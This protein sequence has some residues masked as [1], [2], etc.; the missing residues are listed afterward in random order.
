MAMDFWE[1]QR[2]A[3]KRTAWC[4]FI[5]ILMTVAVAIVSESAMR[6]FAQENYDPPLPYLAFTF[7]GLTFFVALFQ[8]GQFKAFGGAYVAESLGGLRIDPQRAT[9]QQ[10]Q[11][12]NI[13]EEIAVASSLPVPPVYLLPANEINAFAAGLTPQDAVIAVTVGSLN[14]LTRDELQG[15]IAHEFGHVSNA[16]MTISM[17][18]AAMVMGFFFI[19]TIGLRMLRV[20]GMRSSRDSKKG[21]NPIALAA[22]ILVAAGAFTWLA[23]SILKCII[24]RERE[25]LADASS[26]QFTRNPQGIAG[27]LRKIADEQVHDMPKSGMAYSHMYFEDTSMFSA[28]FATHPPI[29]KRIAAVLGKPRT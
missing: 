2:R 28:L 3:R 20:S 23:G 16:D 4:I 5:F 22:L 15:V 9:P 11:L 14:K 29:E 19:L 17:R 1:A 25:Y 21:G 18:I 24:S 13:V 10:K 6:Y 12:L 27:A 7:L 26:V 8:Y